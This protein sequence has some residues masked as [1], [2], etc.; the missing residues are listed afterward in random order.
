MRTWSL[1]IITEFGD[2]VARDADPLPIERDGKP[3]LGVIIKIP[4]KK[5]VQDY[6]D[7]EDCAPLRKFRQSF[8]AATA[9]DR[10]PKRTPYLSR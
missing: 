8:A 5:S 4:D 9:G 1:P 10:R 2:P 7:S 3:A 6:F